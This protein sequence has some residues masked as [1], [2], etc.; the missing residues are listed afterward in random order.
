MK[1]CY[2]I[3]KS[4]H[5]TEKAA[6]LESL[7]SAE[8]N[9]SVRAC[10]T[11]KFVFIV[12]DQATKPEIARAVEQ[13]YKEKNIKVLKVN[14]LRVKPKATTRGRG[15]GR[16]GKSAGFKKAIVTLQPGDQIDNV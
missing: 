1:D 3:V 6:V 9:P 2:A 7:Q 14:T 10:K 13:I 16:P 15:R 8:S 11:P 4:R 12:D 5:I